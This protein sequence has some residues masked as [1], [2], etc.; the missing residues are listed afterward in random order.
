MDDIKMPLPK[1]D[2]LPRISC[3]TE[4]KKA[5]EKFRKDKP[6]SYSNMIRIAFEQTWGIPTE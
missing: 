1:D 4:Y 6:I 3:S 2:Y 5:V